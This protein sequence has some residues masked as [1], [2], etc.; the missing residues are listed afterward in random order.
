MVKE[1]FSTTP[2]NI[3]FRRALVGD[4]LHDWL[5][6]V[7][8]LLNIIL[9]EGRD[10]FTWSLQ[11]NGCFTVY[12]MYKN[13]VNSGIKVIQEIWHAKIPLKIKIFMRYLKRGV[14]HTK[15]NL[16]MQNWIGSKVCSFFNR[17]IGYVSGELSL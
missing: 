17:H 4:K 12:D 5:R 7:D 6:I 9:Q 13:L 15:N 8:M 2:L 3:S 16:A 10:N 1:V 11:A 14:L